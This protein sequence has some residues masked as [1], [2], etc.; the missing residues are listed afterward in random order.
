MDTEP[1]SLHPDFRAEYRA[2]IAQAYL[3]DGDLGRAQMRLA[4]L[5]DENPAAALEANRSR[6]KKPTAPTGKFQALAALSG[7]LR[8]TSRWF[9]PLRPAAFLDARWR[10]DA[11][12]TRAHPH[13]AARSNDPDPDPDAPGDLYAPADCHPQ[14]GFKASFV[15]SDR[16]EVCDPELPEGLLRSQ[17]SLAPGSRL[18]ACAP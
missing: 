15:L 2:L 12:G 1:A 18:R 9:L 16:Q 11:P 13:P 4:L 17:S 3:A 10:R 7:G 8:N 5:Q 14:S 6:R